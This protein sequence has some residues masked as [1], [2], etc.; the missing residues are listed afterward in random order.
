MQ[1]EVELPR[2]GA[3]GQDLRRRTASRHLRPRTHTR[4]PKL[5]DRANTRASPHARKFRQYQPCRSFGPQG[6][7]QNGMPRRPAIRAR[8]RQTTAP[9]PVDREEMTG[10]T[11]ILS[12][13][14]RTLPL[15]GA[16]VAGPLTRTI[17]GQN[18]RRRACPPPAHRLVAGPS[19]LPG[20]PITCANPP[21]ALGILPKWRRPGASKFVI[22]SV[23]IAR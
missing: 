23:Q 10:A 12:G 13:F 5:P 21:C 4:D 11:V 14:G 9:S 17:G 22:G 6:Q 1:E 18:A 2:R 19:R 15:L 7:R 8:D 3:S 16:R 20:G